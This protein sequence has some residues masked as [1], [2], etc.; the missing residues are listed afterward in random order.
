MSESVAGTA[1]AVARVL[2]HAV[3]TA[4]G[5]KSVVP[6][7]HMGQR[8]MVAPSGFAAASWPPRLGTHNPFAPTLIPC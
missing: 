7:W 8:T 4:E 6:T 1:L 5:G 3:R 2:T